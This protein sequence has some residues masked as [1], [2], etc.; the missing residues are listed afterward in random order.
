M[1]DPDRLLAETSRTFALSIPR[2]PEPV[3]AEVTLAYLLFRIADTFED[4]A[5]WPRERRLRALSDFASLL[6]VYDPARA[7]EL[8]AEWLREPPCEHQGYLELLA[9]TPDVLARTQRLDAPAR[10]VVLGH[11][12]RTTYGM[13]GFVERSDARGSLRLDDLNDLTRY[14]YIVAGIVGEL[15]TD[16][17]LLAAPSLSKVEGALRA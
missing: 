12:L 3:R 15:L 1:G 5:P 8:S 9:E 10:A 14:C 11:A 17:F 7:E 4:A 2:L 13:A 16:L 6:T